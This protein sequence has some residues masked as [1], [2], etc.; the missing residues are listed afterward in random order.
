MATR[1]TLFALP[2]TAK[3]AVLS[4]GL[5][6][7]REVSLR[8]G[9][10]CLA[11]LQRLGY[12]QTVLIDAGPDIA[13][14]LV[15]QGIEVAFL[16]LHGTYG[17]DGC[18]QGLLE[19]LGIAYTGNRVAA[20]AIAMDKALTKRLLKEAGLP[21]LPG[22]TLD[23]PDAESVL[24]EPAIEIIAQTV[25]FPL[26]V[27]PLSEGSSIGMSKVETSEELE[28]ALKTAA[29]CGPKVLLERFFKGKDLTVGVVNLNGVPTVTPILELRPKSGWYDL[30]AK[31]TKGLTEFILPAELTPKQAEAIQQ[32][33][34]QAHQALGCHGVSRTDFVAGDNGFYILETNT[35]PGMTDLSDLPAQCAAM[36]LGYDEL[37][38]ALLQTAVQGVTLSAKMH[39][40]L[41]QPA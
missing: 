39:A 30:K 15:A 2:K 33:A 24:S 38:D 6:A 34:L 8:S 27:K 25:G 29:Q 4:G 31:Y 5:S 7:E 17:E 19:W 32:A 3:I 22:L 14:T 9:N 16:T 10:N 21:V 23:L 12:S 41:E 40:L 20:S 11:A 18:I 26:M 28:E 35:I 1:K 37:V 13:K 36:G